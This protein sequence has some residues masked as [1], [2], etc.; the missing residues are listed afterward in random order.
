VDRTN[1]GPKAFLTTISAVMIYHT[2]VK[3]AN[4][5][6]TR[7]VRIPKKSSSPGTKCVSNEARS[8]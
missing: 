6:L 7:D 1:R 8:S 2:I 5:P 3:K 4:D